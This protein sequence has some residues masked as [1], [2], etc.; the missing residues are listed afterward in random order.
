MPVNFVGDSYLNPKS[1]SKRF[2]VSSVEF[3]H[4]PL[5]NIFT[6]SL[7]IPLFGRRNSRTVE[8]S[9]KIFAR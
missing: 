9:H 7:V 5:A 8:F 6:P 1:F 2:S 4:R 3:L